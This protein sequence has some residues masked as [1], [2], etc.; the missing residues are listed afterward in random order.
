VTPGRIAAG[1]FGAWLRGFRAA[2]RD[3]LDSDVACGTC[4]GCC[5][6][7][8]FITLRPGDVAARRRIPA[9]YLVTAPNAAPGV[10]LMGYDER[11]H[12]P[13]LRCGRCS[14]YADRPQTCRTYD[15]RVYAAAGLSP[16][17]DKPAIAARVLEWEFT[18]ADDDA[19]RAHAA[20]RL[21]AKFIRDDAA[22]F[23]R[24]AVP[25]RTGEV[26]VAALKAYEAFLELRV[27]DGR[28]HKRSL[29]E[30]TIALVRA[31]D[32]APRV[33]ADAASSTAPGE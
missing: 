9:E 25:G 3:D 23:P 27:P 5:T 16:G 28:E 14:I 12:C 26:A 33:R 17:A 21:A 30:R 31:F 11:G 8:Y 18:Y 15:C 22:S 1:E 19:R 7:A 13:M 32:A 10:H 29:A 6:S 4:T 24:G 20:V 2:L